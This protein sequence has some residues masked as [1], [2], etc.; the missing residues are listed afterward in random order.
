MMPGKV[1]KGHEKYEADCNQCHESFDRKKQSGLCRKCHKKIDSDI[2]TEIGYHGKIKNVKKKECNVCHTD[3]KGR[4][5]DIIKLDKQTFNHMQTDFPLKGKHTTVACQSCHIPNKKYRQAANDCYSCHKKSDIHNK[6]LGKKCH[7][8]HS[9]KNWRTT[10]FN[11]NKTNFK[12]TG[13]HN[14]ISCESCHINQNY[15]NTPKKCVRCHITKDIHAGEFGDRCEKCHKSDKWTS[16]IFS[17]NHDTKFNLTGSHKKN[18]CDSCHDKNPYKHITPK[19]CISCHKQDD[20][21]RGIFGKKCQTCHQTTSWQKHH[22]NHNKDTNYKLENKHAKAHCHDCHQSNAYKLR[23]N[24]ACYDCHRLDDTHQ[25][26]QGKSCNTCHSTISWNS[27][28]AFDHDLSDFPLIG[29]HASVSCDEC[30]ADSRYKKTP[31]TCKSCHQQVDMHKGTFGTKCQTCH[32]PNSWKRW[33][34]D[35]N[36]KTDFL[37]KD[38]HDQLECH[39]CHL[40]D[41]KNSMPGRTCNEC[42]ANDDIHNGGFGIQCERCHTM[43]SFTNILMTR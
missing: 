20:S 17:H 12:L 18:S 41:N 3:H 38:A 43:D 5:V 29:L 42:H 14:D 2:R 36:R 37:L 16:I 23:K 4:N 33:E 31:N 24:R 19:Q 21:H 15:N 25:G 35:H 32:N 27:K 34:F 7:Q 40:L 22:F 9:E 26:S 30:H 28:V 10:R 6:Q 1:I 13:K 39:A 8:C 11:H